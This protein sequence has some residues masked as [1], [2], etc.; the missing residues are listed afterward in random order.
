MRILIVED[1]FISRRILQKHLAPF[2]ICEIAVNGREGMKAFSLAWEEGKLYRLIFLDIMMPEMDG[3]E[4]LK[5]IRSMEAEKRIREEDRAKILMTTAR[6]DSA[7]VLEVIQAQCNDYLVKPIEKN[8]LLEKLK[9]L[10]F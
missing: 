10:G 5:N 3:K 7:S 4:V 2:G 9:K 1:D 6:N 8:K